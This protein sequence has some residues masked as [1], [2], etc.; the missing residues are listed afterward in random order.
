[1]ASIVRRSPVFD[2]ADVLLAL[3]RPRRSRWTTPIR[4]FSSRAVTVVSPA[5]AR[6]SA[7][8]TRMNCRMWGV[9]RL[10]IAICDDPQPSRER[11]VK[12]AGGVTRRAAAQRR[13]AQP[14][15]R[16]VSGGYPAPPT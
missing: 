11:P 6:T 2:R 4:G 9:S 7:C 10:T 1:M 8:R 5:W 12:R 3:I 13:T 16:A 15:T 14:L